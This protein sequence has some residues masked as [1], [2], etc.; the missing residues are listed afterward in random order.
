MIPE[1]TTI[2][3]S[4]DLGCELFGAVARIASVN[5]RIIFAMRTASWTRNG[6]VD[7][8]TRHTATRK[9]TAT[10]SHGSCSTA[11]WRTRRSCGGRSMVT[12]IVLRLMLLKRVGGMVPNAVNL[13]AIPRIGKNNTVTT[14]HLD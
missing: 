1:T 11:A 6:V 4:E 12:R 9:S 3:P 8:R 13:T 7:F 10:A 5:H 2:L 14:F